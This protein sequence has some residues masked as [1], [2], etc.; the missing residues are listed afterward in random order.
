MFEHVLPSEQ[1]EPA[2]I[3]RP[4]DTVGL[5]KKQFS[6]PENVKAYS[7]VGLFPAEEKLIDKYFK[8]GSAVLDIGCGAGRT[9]IH[10]AKKG[11]AVVGIDLVPEMIEAAK[12]QAERQ[13]VNVRFDV[14]DAVTMKFHREAFDNV[15]F[16]YN[17]FD[18]IQGKRNRERV[19][20]NVF[21]IIKPGGCFMMTT[22][23]AFGRRILMW[24]LI[25][26]LFL[27]HKLIKKRAEWELGDK[28]WNGQYYHYLNKAFTGCSA[29]LS[30]FIF[31]ACQSCFLRKI[32]TA[33]SA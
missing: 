11:H 8:A 31:P 32:L 21:E 3:R 12:R 23:S 18:Q 2:V 28:I 1:I 4:L 15:L 25:A 14:T 20:R 19:L 24:G 5:V 30:R 26:G 7:T 16:A 9:T 22:R 10:L 27:H 6:D 13:R 17:G 33:R 29:R